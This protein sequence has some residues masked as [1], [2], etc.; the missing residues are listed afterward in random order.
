MTKF[1]GVILAVLVAWPQTAQATVVMKLN[2]AEMT[3]MSEVV[4]R[5]R[6]GSMTVREESPGRLVTLI[7]LETLESFKG[8][9]GALITVQQS[10][11][12]KGDWHQTIPGQSI[13]RPGEELVLFLDRLVSERYVTV[14]IGIGR[15]VIERRTDGTVIAN[16]DLGHVTFAAAGADGVI[17][18]TAAPQPASLSLVDLRRE[19]DGYLR[20][21]R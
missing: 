6:V 13:Y 11:G 19:L 4:V 9:A 8:Q 20:R 15:F 3:R 18:P 5:A 10:G 21:G 16:E 7:E 2:R 14:G 12:V 17:R 1:L